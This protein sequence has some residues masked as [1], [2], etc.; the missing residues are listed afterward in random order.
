MQDTT[1][2]AESPALYDRVVMVRACTRSG[3]SLSLFA[4]TK[5]GAHALHHARRQS[6]GRTRSRARRLLAGREVAL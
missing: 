6:H 4:V 3:R 5:D 2:P 1:S